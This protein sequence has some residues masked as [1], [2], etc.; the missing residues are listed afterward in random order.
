[1][2]SLVE[3]V[4]NEEGICYKDAHNRHPMIPI[5]VVLTSV[6]TSDFPPDSTKKT[7]LDLSGSEVGSACPVP[8]PFVLSLLLR[9]WDYG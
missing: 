2:T 3:E 5:I 7:L 4:D 6:I 8:L 9:T 1:M